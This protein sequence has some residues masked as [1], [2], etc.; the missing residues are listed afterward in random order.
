VAGSSCSGTSVRRH[1]RTGQGAVR[2][3]RSGRVPDCL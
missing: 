3:H 1:G 2:V